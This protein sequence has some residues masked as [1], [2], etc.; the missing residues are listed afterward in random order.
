[1]KAFLFFLLALLISFVTSAGLLFALLNFVFPLVKLYPQI[2]GHEFVGLFTNILP[3]LISIFGGFLIGYI[4]YFLLKKNK[5]IFTGLFLLSLAIGWIDGTVASMVGTIG[6]KSTLL[7][8]VGFWMKFPSIN[9]I[10]WNSLIPYF[11]VGILTYVYLYN[12]RKIPRKL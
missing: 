1:M 4:G 10:Y 3:W 2:R 7:F 8:F 5:V 6:L 9:T 12:K 11:A